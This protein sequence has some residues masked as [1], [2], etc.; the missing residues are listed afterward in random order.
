[1]SDNELDNLFK[2]AADGFNT[3]HDP[4]AWKQ[5]AKKLDAAGNTAGFW[6]WK[7]ISMLTAVGITA[8]LVWYLSVSNS[9]TNMNEAANVKTDNQGQNVKPEIGQ[10]ETDDEEVD[11]VT[12]Q[13][14]G[15]P[16][17]D[18]QI[19][20]NEV[21]K[22][23]AQKI[24]GL[25]SNNRKE[26]QT[27]EVSSAVSFKANVE[28]QAKTTASISKSASPHETTPETSNG[29]LKREGSAEDSTTALVNGVEQSSVRLSTD[30]T[31]TY[32]PDAKNESATIQKRSMDE[33]DSLIKKEE[34][35]SI[36]NTDSASL[37]Q[38]VEKV[39]DEKKHVNRF[40][41]VKAIAGVDLS[42]I[43]FFTLDDP[44]FNYGLL[45]GYSFNDRWSVYSGAVSSRKIYT[46]NDIEEGYT[47]SSGYDYPINQLE[48]DCRVLDIPLN[49]Y[50]TFFPTRSFS[51]RAG[52]GFSSY[53][54]LSED[55]VYHVDNPYGSDVYYQSISRENNEWFKIL[56]VSVVLQK[57]LNEKFSLE[58]EPYLKAPLAGVGEG[59]VSLVSLGAFFNVRYDIPLHK[60]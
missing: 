37:K 23:S 21:E 34:E 17:H 52:L 6:N 20:E 8:G 41:S 56:N 49:I 12:L 43:K 9:D 7:T 1:M 5:M 22:I 46:S 11:R 29:R 31:A 24:Q 39:S 19:D 16:D 3:P 59:E 15:R 38:N 18:M 2:E 50:Y 26:A 32:L 4:T 45:V 40:I 53:I 25:A 51:V 60:K 30:P 14:E 13:R 57:R 55:Y 42:S 47:N 36:L 27:K 44:G 33:P 28:N 10:S 35:V 58:L 48:G 54:M